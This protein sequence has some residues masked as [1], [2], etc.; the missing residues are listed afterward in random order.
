MILSQHV[1]DWTAGH[2]FLERLFDAFDAN[3]DKTIDLNE[4]LDGLSVFVKGTAEEKMELSF[5]IY[6]FDHKGYVTQK[7][8]A[9]FLNQMVRCMVSLVPLLTYTDSTQ[10]FT[11]SIKH[12]RSMK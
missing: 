12:N 7:E 1:Q 10:P 4:F 11:M 6:D 2:M 5:R 3:G 8:I 9:R